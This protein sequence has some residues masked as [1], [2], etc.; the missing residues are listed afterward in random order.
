MKRN[1][2]FYTGI[3]LILPGLFFF[4][5]TNCKGGGYV[6]IYNVIPS[7]Q[8]PAASIGISAVAG[9][10][11]VTIGWSSVVSAV[12]YDIYRSLISGQTGTKIASVNSSTTSYIDGNLSNGTTLFYTIA[13]LDKSGEASLTS[14]ISSTPTS[15]PGPIT[16]SGMVQYQDKEYGVDGFTPSKPYKKVR[17]ATIELISSDSV[18]SAVTDS[19]G[20]YSIQ[21]PASNIAYVRVLAE[22]TLPRAIAPQIFVNN[23]RN[24]PYA[25]GSNDFVVSGSA[26]VNISIPTSLIAGAF[27]ILDV[28]TNGVEFIYSLSGTYPAADLNAYWKPYNYEGTYYCTGGCN[29]GKGIYVY[30]D[31]SSDTDE[32]DD[33]V[34]YHEFGHFAADK[35][36]Q[37]DSPGGLHRLTDP[38]LDMRLTW[39]EGWGDAFPGM[40]KTWLNETAPEL[41]SSITGLT[42]Y[43]DT[44][45]SGARIVIDMGNPDG[46]FKDHYDYA[47]SEIAVAKI[48]LDISKNFSVQDI[49]DVMTSDYFK[50]D[51]TLVNL[52]TFWDEWLAAGKSITPVLEK[53]FTD[54]QIFYSQDDNESNNS[55]AAATAVVPGM[56]YT[57]TL[58]GGGD[59]DYF[60][61]NANENQSFTITTTNL[62]NGADTYITL[63]NPDKITL[64]SGASSNPNDNWNN[65]TYLFSSDP[66]KV[67]SDYVDS[68]CESLPG[69]P[70]HSGPCHENAGDVLGSR[71]AFTAQVPGV[72][73]IVIKSSP[74]APFSAG[75]YGTYTLTIT[76]TP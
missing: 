25:V 41:L 69:Y 75:K 19:N 64:T 67:P 47:T 61:F 46:Q 8:T 13:A 76:S 44:E 21:T 27:N 2:Y 4:F 66:P 22:A 1:F 40:V 31:P 30:S 73:Y 49:W 37:D 24:A 32:Y 34:L 35:F 53:F 11:T 65:Y 9:D 57:N 15:T 29:P 17:Y 63:Y 51:S 3:L 16:V 23:L 74:T 18:R 28:L 20:Y 38:D 36:S 10:K 33:D 50:T 45:A 42:E 6:P 39:S 56:N 7:E 5:L 43:V 60:W 26:N 54:R 71:I 12:S 58:Y 68:L 48:L 14:Q 62:I 70:S 59:V 72:Y 55:I 52:E